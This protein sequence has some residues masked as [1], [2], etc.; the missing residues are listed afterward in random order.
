MSFDDLVDIYTQ[1]A[2]ALIEGGVDLLLIE[3]VFDT[4]NCKAA[5]FAVNTIKEERGL[6]IPVMVSGTITDASGRTL[7]GQTTEAFYISIAHGNLFSV[8][9]NCALGA[10]QM[11]PFLA[12]LS[13]VAQ[14][15]VSCYPN[16]GLPNEFGEY[17]ESPEAMAEN[18]K[19]FCSSGFVNV[20]GGCC[21]TTPEHIKAIAEV[22]NE[23]E[24]R[25]IKELA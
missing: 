24:P 20:V 17:D 5:L 11:R 12:S 18:L 6:D 9:L 7:S 16:A 3:T 1:Q 14:C 15:L 8:G 22:A 4:L 21:G 13:D 25:K 2:D 10:E 23:F 19:D